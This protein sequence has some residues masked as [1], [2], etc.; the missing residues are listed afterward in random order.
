MDTLEKLS[1]QL[2]GF[3]LA[4]IGISVTFGVLYTVGAA[5]RRKKQNHG[6]A[7]AAGRGS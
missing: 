2:L 5:L 7:D 1:G 6:R 3:W 4:I